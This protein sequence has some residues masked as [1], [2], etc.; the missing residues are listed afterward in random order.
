MIQDLDKSLI[1][2]G[3]PTVKVFLD[4]FEIGHGSRIFLHPVTILFHERFT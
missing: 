2:S 3:E 4:I 1:D